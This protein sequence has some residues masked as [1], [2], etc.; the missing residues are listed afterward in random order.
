MSILNAAKRA[1]M[2]KSEFALPGSEGFPLNDA[3]H[4]RMAISGATRSE[5]AGNISESTADKIKGEA[6]AKLRAL[7]VGRMVKGVK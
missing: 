4:D 2:P 6:R 3:T 1:L 5:H 7:M